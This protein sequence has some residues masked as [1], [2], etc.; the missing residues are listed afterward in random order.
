MIKKFLI[1]VIVFMTI[2]PVF[3]Q[4]TTNVKTS[5]Q[6]KFSDGPYI[7]IE[8]NNL[9]K[10]SIIN[11]Q[12]FSKV[13]E[14]N[15]YDT[16]FNPDK[17]V[18]NNIRKIAALSDIHGQYDLA[19]EILKNNKV[20]DSKLNWN[21]GKGHLIIVGDIFDRGDKVN[22]TLWLIYKL[23][24]QA[25]RKGGRVHFLLGNHEY[26]IL[27]KDLRYINEKYKLTSKLLNVDYDE[28]Y[29]KKT[30]IGRWLRS[31]PTIV[32]I[33]NN[34]FV[35]GGISKD[36]LAQNDFN[37][38]NIN[39][40]M[41]S[42]IDRSKK[43]M[44][45]TDF[46]KT[47]YGNT[48]LIWYRGYFRDNLKDKDISDILTDISSKHIIVGHC[49]NKEVVSLFNNKVFGVDSSIKKGEYGELLFIKNGKYFRKTLKGNKIQ[50]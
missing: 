32:K 46:Y 29:G 39:D 49:S 33:N 40:I 47:Y 41:R 3:C 14:P 1:V 18:F 23:E 35:H 37:I 13:L 30:L 27:H 21:F 19:I 25:K 8:N 15:A 16:I 31:K 28:L 48:S 24:H 34:V 5:V 11:G 4:N 12:V 38:K 6:N 2:S 50:F 42:S 43:E 20:I 17:A 9:I 44:K 36:F 45:S 7:F 26:M 10:K 22:E